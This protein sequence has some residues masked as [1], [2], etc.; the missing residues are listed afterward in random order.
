MAQRVGD[1]EAEAAGGV[2]RARAVRQAE[3]EAA[4]AGGAPKRD[5]FSA[6]GGSGSAV[7]GSGSAAI[8]SAMAR[9]SSKMAMARP[10][11]RFGARD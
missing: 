7:S 10:L 5:I 6:A 8:S 11:G 1:G 3:V 9:A 2:C 4:G